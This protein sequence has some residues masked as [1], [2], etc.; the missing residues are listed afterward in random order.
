MSGSASL[1]VKGQPKFTAGRWNPHSNATQMATAN[2]TS[3]RLWDLRTMEYVS[4]I[5]QQ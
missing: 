3:I 2:D 4:N 5:A 1:E